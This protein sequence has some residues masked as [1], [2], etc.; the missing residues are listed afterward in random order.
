MLC[1]F[2]LTILGC[3]I[4]SILALIT[5]HMIIFLNEYHFSLYTLYLVY[6]PSL[7]TNTSTPP[8]SVLTQGI[9]SYP[10]LPSTLPLPS[11]SPLLWAQNLAPFLVTT[12]T[13]STL[14]LALVSLLPVTLTSLHPFFLPLPLN[15]LSW[16]RC[17]FPV[18]PSPA[19]MIPSPANS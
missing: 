10:A 2:C 14:N 12:L 8:S 9:P 6:T 17:C 19:P 13:L 15:L 16:P 11:A 3:P 4:T 5:A 1:F 7:V 18:I